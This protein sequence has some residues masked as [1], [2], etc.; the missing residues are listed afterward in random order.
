VPLISSARFSNALEL[1]RN[2]YQE[3][4]RVRRANIPVETQQRSFKEIFSS[5]LGKGQFSVQPYEVTQLVD[6]V[7]PTLPVRTNSFFDTILQNLITSTRSS[8]VQFFEQIP[9]SGINSPNLEVEIHSNVEQVLS[10][11]NDSRHFDFGPDQLSL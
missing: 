5:S 6:T 10:F 4:Q 2:S 8:G 7:P 11:L 3:V 1:A 9:S